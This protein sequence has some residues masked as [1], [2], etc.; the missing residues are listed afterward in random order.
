MQVSL[1]GFI[2]GPD[3]DMS[4]MA[5]D[6]QQQW[7]D[8]FE[9]LQSVDLFLL[10][11]VMFPDYKNYWKQ[12]LTNPLASSNERAYARLAEKTQHLVFSHTMKNPEWGNTQII[13]GPVAAQVAKLKQQPGKD[14]QVVGGAKL[15]ATLIEAGLID[16]YR[17]IINPAIMG[18]GKSFFRDQATK[19]FLELISTKTLPSGVL[20][21]RYKGK[22]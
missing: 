2:E 13:K 11:R 17:L 22:R 16:E 14:I 1:D 4:W 5:K 9:M 8:L 18:T 12:A 20:I 7:D 15:S 21:V 10:G 3:G 19:Q 6:D